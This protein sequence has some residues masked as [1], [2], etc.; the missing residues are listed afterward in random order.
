M[1][2]VVCRYFCNRDTFGKRSVG[3]LFLSEGSHP[4]ESE[5]NFEFRLS[6]SLTKSKQAPGQNPPVTRKTAQNRSRFQPQLLSLF[7][8]AAVAYAAHW[9]TNDAEPSRILFAELVRLLLR[10]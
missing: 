4:L 2:S 8:A 10:P 6:V 9:L 5:L 3:A 1:L 7:S